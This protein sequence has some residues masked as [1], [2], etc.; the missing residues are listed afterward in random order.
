M[1]EP[2]MDEAFERTLERRL[3]DFADEAVRPFDAVEISRT[4]ASG[5]GTAM[6]WR[7]LLPAWLRPI[8][9][10]ASLVLLL[11]AVGIAGGFIRLPTNDLLPNPSFEPFSPFPGSPLP[12]DGLVATGE[13]SGV[14]TFVPG[15][16]PPDTS[17]PVTPTSV[18]ETIPP[19]P[20]IPPTIG[21]TAEPTLILEPTPTFGTPPLAPTTEPTLLPGATPVSVVDVSAGDTH[22]CTISVDGRVFC[23]GA[24]EFGELGDG[25]TEDRYFPTTPVVG[26]T[27]AID[28]AAGNRFTCALRSGGTIACW[29]EAGS[30]QLGNGGTSNSSA[31]V[32]VAG[33]DDALEITAGSNHACARRPGAGVWCWGQAMDVGNGS[34]TNDSTPVPIPVQVSNLDDAVEISAGWNHTCARRA[35]GTIACWG[36]NGDGATGYGQLGDGTLDDASTPVGVVGI[37][38]AIA[39]GAGGWTTCA[40]RADRSVWCWG[41][42]ERGGL[43]DANSVNGAVPVQVVGIDNATSVTVGGWHSCARLTTGEVRCWGANSWGGSVG[44]LGDGTSIDRSTPVTVQGLTNAAQIDA[45]WIVSYA[46]GEDG[47]L[48]GWGWYHGA[49]PADIRVLDE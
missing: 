43:G 37:D 27:D 39:V 10:A 48:W 33:V 23:F 25:T 1:P 17:A 15:S 35:D 36:L 41:Y 46:A 7:S 40:V 12:S 21:P 42:G 26:V 29:G 9:F 30:G 4:A 16:P 44:Q 20:T 6:G 11:A 45:G 38:D 22:A 31:P 28:V 8:A 24:N 47:R 13:A 34:A 14:P 2:G 49:V 19:L 3:R 18:L 5:R 32:T